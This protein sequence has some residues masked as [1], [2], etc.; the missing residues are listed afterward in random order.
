MSQDVPSIQRRRRGR[1]VDDDDAE[2]VTAETVKRSKRDTDAWRSEKAYGKMNLALEALAPYVDG[3][4]ADF[5]QYAGGK[6]V[7]RM[8]SE[9]AADG[10]KQ[11]AWSCPSRT[12]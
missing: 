8:A 2:E 10:Q 5:V 1:V 11:A 7:H 3:P 9:I 12:C 4:V 6:K